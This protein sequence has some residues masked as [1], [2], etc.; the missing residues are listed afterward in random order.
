MTSHPTP[1]LAPIL[2]LL[3]PTLLI[4]AADGA[5]VVT[6]R[7]TAAVTLGDVDAYIEVIPTEQRAGFVDSGERVEKMLENLLLAEQLANSQREVEKAKGVDPLLTARLRFVE[8]EARAQYYL[9]TMR[10]DAPKVDAKALA[11]EAYAAAPEQFRLPDTFDLRHVLVKTGDRPEAAARELIDKVHADALAHPDQFAELAKKYSE[12]QSNREQGGLLEGVDLATLT[13]AFAA[14]AQA[15]SRPGEV[16]PVV[17]TPY[18]LHVIQLV[19]RHPGK[20]RS[21]ESVQKELEAKVSADAAGRWAQREI[22]RL[23]NIPAQTDDAVA[24]S[25]RTRYGEPVAKTP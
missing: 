20:E 24:N 16:S 6:K 4:A 17:Q 5:K 13:P 2:L 14:A 21:F 8:N 3:I 1:R 18:G 22:E 25:I 11:R 10:A 23:Q 7:G 9:A 12:D 19:E 15:L